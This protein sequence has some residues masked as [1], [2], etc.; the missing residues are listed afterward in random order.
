[1]IRILYTALLALLLS[2]CASLQPPAPAPETPDQALAAALQT[3]LLEGRIGVRV[4]DRYDSASIQWQQQR[5]DYRIHLSA[6]PF[7]QSVARFE[8]GPGHVEVHL[9]GEDEYYMAESPEA[10]MQALLGWNLP[11]SHAQWWVRGLPDPYLPHTPRDQSSQT[12]DQAGWHVE[13]S[14]Y[15]AVS[16]ELTL[17]SRLRMRHGDLQVTLSIHQ[18]QLR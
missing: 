1:M 16:S 9:A 12:F 13:I 2:A 10:L 14:R 6:G 15:Q 8:G 11:V 4:G 18:W 17:P 7:N 5:N 3:W